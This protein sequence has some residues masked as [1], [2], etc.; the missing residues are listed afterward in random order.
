[1]SAT[2]LSLPAGRRRSDYARLAL[3]ARR[4]WPLLAFVFFCGLANQGCGLGVPVV[5][6]LLVARVG[7]GG[8]R[9]EDLPP[10]LVALVAL[11][12][13][14]AVFTWL[15]GWL[16]HQ[17]AYGLLAALRKTAYDALE[18]LA[19][20]Y[21]QKRR[22]GDI[23]TMVMNDIETL[24]TF[25]AHAL[26]PVTVSILVPAAILVALAFFA[27]V[28]VAVLLPFMVAVAGLP[29]LGRHWGE[30]Q[31]RAVAERRAEVN[32]H[33]VDSVQGLREILS[34]G[35]GRAR[36]EEVRRGSWA[37]GR[38]QLRH[39]RFEGGLA[40]AT[41]TLV[42]LGGL[43]VLLAAV[44]LVTSGAVDRFELPLLLLLSMGAFRPVI[45]LAA[46]ARTLNEVAVA[47]RRY[48]T[49]IDEPV[50]VLEHTADSPG[51]RPPAIEFRDVTFAYLADEPPVLRD[52]TFAVQPGETVALVG[53]SGAGKSTCASLLLRFWDPQA[54]E[55]R[56]GGENLRDF[57]LEDL[58]RRIAVVQQD[59]Y[60]FNASIRENLKLGRPE[61]T[62]EEVEAAARQANIH[63]FI[64]SLPEGYDTIAG[65][66]GLKLSG[67]Q[68]QRLAIA[69]ALLKDAPIL[70]LD[71]ATSNLDSEN[72]R[73]IRAAIARLMVGRTALVIAHRLSSIVAADRVVMLERGAVVATGRHADLVAE[74]GAYARL[75]AAQRRP[76]LGGD[77]AEVGAGSTDAG[78]G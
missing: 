17:V 75:I 40:G 6:A 19:P 28:L 5:S 52:V 4:D 54:G 30:A 25:F 59:N 22:T 56:L 11:A 43:S 63:D 67:G 26:V 66:R 44:G 3:M 12:L 53:P 42:V 27:P 38:A 61:A 41:E 10:Y 2:P 76:A 55:I 39:S 78:R 65:E 1:M 46:I 18:P 32:A 20:A 34:F 64:V 7:R 77:A 16:A 14:K 62:Q 57:P 50:L 74:D 37:L 73:A 9:V 31:A 35:R 51:P 69:R 70:I 47:T 58:R 29:V 33:M 72:E 13:G 60:L 45:D 15:E 49:V 21:T 8:M 68:R 71:E 48:F 23:T 24:E 36:A